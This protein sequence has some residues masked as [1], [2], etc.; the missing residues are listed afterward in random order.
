MSIMSVMP[1]SL[2]NLWHPFSFSSPYFPDSGTF[3]LSQLFASDDQNTGV[4]SSAVVL[5]INIQGWFPLRLT[6][7]I[8]LL[9][10]GF[11]GVFSSTTVQRH[12][13]FGTL[14]SFHPKVKKWKSLS[15]VQ[16]SVTPWTAAC[17]APLSMD[18]SRP[19]NW[20]V[21]PFLS[22][23]ELPNT[24]IEPRSPALQANSLL[25]EPPGKPSLHPKMGTMK[26]RNSRDLV[27]AEE[28]KTKWKEYTEE[29]I[30]YP[31]INSTF[32]FFKHFLM[33][34]YNLET[35]NE[36]VWKYFIVFKWKGFIQ[37][38]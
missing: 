32:L 5:P 35:G 19:E 28:M 6:S 3:P 25:Y 21:L 17:H 23:E 9:F 7:F 29:Q 37:C 18:F 12:Q 33:C 2:L 26:E 27:G 24:G 4:S 10:Q 16:L 1:S 38:V 15:H 11:S 31:V 8:S 36:I 20:R 13:F 34:I 14:P 22:P 30:Y